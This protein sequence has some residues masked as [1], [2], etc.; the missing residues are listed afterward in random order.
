MSFAV[1]LLRL[2]LAVIF[3]TAGLAKLADRNGFR[4]TVIGFGVSGRAARV[5]ATGLPFAELATAVA[6]IPQPSGRWG[7]V[8]ALALFLVFIAGIS[9]A[10]R[11]GRKP[12]CN[13]FGQLASERIGA[14][15]LVRNG[16]LSLIAAVVIW[17]GPGDSLAA[18]SANRGIAETLAALAVVA[19]V[20]V[21]ILAIR[22]RRG[23]AIL[24]ER[25]NRT[26][27]ELALLPS[28]LPIGLRAP[29]FTLSELRGAKVSLQELCARGRPLILAFTSPSCGPCLRLTPDLERWHGALKERV[30]FAIVSTPGEAPWTAEAVHHPGSDLLT[31]VQESQEVFDQFRVRSTPTAVVIDP[32]G[33]I[34]SGYASGPVEIEELV[35]LTLR[36]SDRP[37]DVNRSLGAPIAA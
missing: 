24:M 3:A 9:N 1:L 6:L 20:M 29:S 11:N 8:A 5:V 22:Y 28:G 31:L 16:V 18:W 30:T 2:A 15:T 12:D 23:T 35:R 32:D 7:G 13:C 34:A 33:R 4:R 21:S 26:G 37:A 36:R 14:S 19:L 25:L 10:L 17:K 27:R